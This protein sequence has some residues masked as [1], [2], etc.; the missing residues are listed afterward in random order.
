MRLAHRAA[1]LAR[2]AAYTVYHLTREGA[3]VALRATGIAE[4]RATPR[5]PTHLEVVWD[6]KF[7]ERIKLRL[8][9]A[10][11]LSR[12]GVKLDTAR[13]FALGAGLFV[14]FLSRNGAASLTVEARVVHCSAHEAARWLV[15]CCFTEELTE[16][17]VRTLLQCY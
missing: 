14:R 8:A 16:D 10:K 7:G 13:E 17:I 11:D 15:G 4:R 5:F 1:A 2:R 6:D 12:G 3:V 9:W